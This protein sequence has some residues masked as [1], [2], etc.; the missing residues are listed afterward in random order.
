MPRP[1]RPGGPPLWYAGAGEAASSRIARHFD[2]WLPYV[3][4]DQ[5]YADHSNR[6]D[7]ALAFAD[8]EPGE[9]TRGLYVRV[10]IDDDV[11]RARSALDRYCEAYYGAPLELMEALQ[12]FVTGSA[13]EVARTLDEFTAAGADHIV[14]RI[15]SLRP[16]KEDIDALADS[17]LRQRISSTA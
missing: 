17:L 8:R 14:V 6:L 15:G 9:V 1:T 4:T 3:P 5:G 12:G 13:D 16:E 11:D 10:H 7:D 2:G